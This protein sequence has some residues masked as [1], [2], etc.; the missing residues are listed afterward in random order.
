MVVY[1][2]NPPHTTTKRLAERKW[3]QASLRWELRG[4]TVHHP[5]DTRGRWCRY[6]STGGASSPR[7][8]LLLM[9][10]AATPSSSFRKR[11]KER[12]CCSSPR[13]PTLPHV[14]AMVAYWDEQH[15][16]LNPQQGTP[17]K[18]HLH[19]CE[20]LSFLALLQ[21]GPKRSHHVLLC[22]NH[23]HNFLV[24]LDTHGLEREEKTESV[25][26]VLTHWHLLMLIWHCLWVL[27]PSKSQLFSQKRC[28]LALAARARAARE[29]E[30]EVVIRKRKTNTLKHF[31][32]CT[33]IPIFKNILSFTM[34][35]WGWEV[36]WGGLV[37]VTTAN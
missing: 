3:K 28:H 9:T 32:M 25:G 6:W 13:P 14:T 27:L 22:S 29:P 35:K 5:L 11:S 37:T 1:H 16:R 33:T 12:L 23:L 20:N 34:K 4:F 26:F 21:A 15:W 24:T 10:G 36:Q 8:S 2:S 17:W 7:R 30:I 31:C 19:L 18:T